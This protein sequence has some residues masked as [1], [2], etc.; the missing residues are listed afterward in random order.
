MRVTNN[1]LVKTMMTNINSN[2]SRLNKLQQQMSTGKKIRVPSD[3]PIIAARALKFRTDVSE[4]EQFKK[5]TE[6]SLSWLEVTENAL[7]SLGDVIHRAR[8]LTVHASN[9][10]LSDDDR[11]KIKAEISQLKK[12]IVEIGNASY[13]GR[14]VFAGYK[15]DEPP[16]EVEDTVVGEKIKYNGK[17][18]S[19]GGPIS[20]SVAG[21]TTANTFETFVQTNLDQISGQPELVMGNFTSFTAAAPN[22]D[23]NI[24]LGGTNTQTMSLTDGTTY[25]ISSAISEIQSKINAATAFGPDQIRVSEDNGRIKLTVLDESVNSIEINNPIPTAPSAPLDVSQLGFADGVKSVRNQKQDIQYEVSIGNRI[26]VNAEGNE[27]FG[28]GVDGLFETFKKLELALDGETSYLTA[29]ISTVS[30]A[31]TTTFSIDEVLSDLDNNMDNLLKV[32][33]DVGARTSFVELTKSRLADDYINFTALM[34]KNE[35]ADMAEV[36]INLQNEQN[37][38]NAS[39]SAGAKIIQPTLVDFIR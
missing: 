27:V 38:Y 16:F 20:S 8:E 35:D 21:P 1:M 10:T 3:D 15:T 6:D 2:L 11:L 13:A 19:I 36:I 7:S 18:L 17:Y 31:S 14:Y 9:G 30:N 32:R 28:S 34:S 12:N 33:A 37:V 39:L 22:L 5:N 24:T 26:K 25:T 4:I 23:F 29:T